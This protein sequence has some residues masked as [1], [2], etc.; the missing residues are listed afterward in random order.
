MLGPDA[1]H[2][3]TVAGAEHFHYREG[4][5]G[6]LIPL[7]GDGI[8]T[9]DGEYHDRARRIMMPAFHRDRLDAAVEAMVSET[10]RALGDWHAGETHDVYAWMRELAMRIAMR[11]LMGLDPDQGGRGHEAAV[12]FERGLAFFATEAWTRALHVPGSP[13]AKM[14]AA[15][16]RLDEILLEEIAARRAS[17]EDA[18]RGDI[19]GMLIGARDEE[20]G[21]GLADHE[22]RDQLLTLLFAGHD[23]SSSTVALLLYELARHPE[24][25]DRVLEEQDRVLAGRAPDIET[26][27]RGLPEL[28]L[29]VDETLRL[30]P[31]AW[32]GARQAVSDFEFGGHHIPAGTFTMYSSWASHH[33]PDVWDEP[34][35]FGPQRFAPEARR[36]IPRGAY[37]P[38]GGGS[39]I[40]IG[41]RF[42]QLVVKTVATMVLQRAAVERVPGHELTLH[43]MP[44][45][46]P[47]GGLPMVVR[48]RSAA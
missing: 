47:K 20:D 22:I 45:I 4:N 46:S 5:M 37:V 3:M 34:F 44:T 32:I 7:I 36:E 6:D 41:K 23:T 1:N 28:D 42:G 30:Y 48:P 14:R 40:C 8:L 12:E 39:R 26:L 11:A 21:A 18:D 29:A 9:T 13:W 25:L 15:R 31:P 38:F 35:A 27:L 43:L 17:G 10:D 33:L 2:F 19:L 24:A 16:R